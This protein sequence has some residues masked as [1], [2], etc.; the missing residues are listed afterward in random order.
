[1]AKLIALGVGAIKPTGLIDGPVVTGFKFTIPQNIQLS[2]IYA[3][4]E[5]LELACGTKSHID[6]RRLGS[7]LV[8]FVPNEPRKVV[9]FKECL[10]WFLKDE[11]V[12]EMQLPILLGVDVEG[13]KKALDLVAQPHI[14]I[15]GSTGSGKSV[16]ESAIIA[17]LTTFYH[18]DDLELYLVDTKRV[19][20]T[21]FAD[22][23]HVKKVIRKVKDWYPVYNSLFATVQDRQKVLESN[24]VRNI[25]EYNQ[26]FPDHKMSYIVLVIDE[27]NDLIE[28][29]KVIRSEDDDHDEPKVIDAIKRLIGIC[30]ASG[31]HIIACTQ[32]TSVDVVTG[33]VKANFPCRIA[34]RVATGVD[35]R[36]I[37]GEQGAENLLGNGDMLVMY[38]DVDSNQ[39]YHGPFVRLED[40]EHILAAQND[41]RKLVRAS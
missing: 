12:A 35:S 25:R 22:L 13:N 40:I 16:Y 33:T 30:R 31:V 34:L 28:H 6:I 1:M 38:P 21:L 36:T 15:A 14:L 3:R 11:K 17:S 19:D 24:G 27:L 5:D 29:D 39:R 7:E 20:L 37:L 9:D 10:W 41:I 4:Q 8:F 26:K 32:R 2:K 23:P 18:P